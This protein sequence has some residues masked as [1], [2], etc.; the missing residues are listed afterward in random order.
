MSS[1]NNKRGALFMEN[2]HTKGIV[3]PII[4]LGLDFAPVLIFVLLFSLLRADVSAILLLPV[5]LAPVI[6][7]ILGVA[8]LRRGKERTGIIGKII[9][10]TAIALP[11]G[12]VAFV[13]IFFIGASVGLIPLM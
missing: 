2:K 5:L 9:A 13:I 8:A 6:G 4:A 12:F 7:V 3:L 11:L 10:I 1:G